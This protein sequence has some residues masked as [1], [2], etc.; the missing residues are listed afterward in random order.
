M[1]DVI[2]C[3]D[4]HLRLQSKYQH[5]LFE[6]GPLFKAWLQQV[7]GISQVQLEQGVDLIELRFYFAEQPWFGHYEHYTDS[8]WLD[9]ES[10]TDLQSMTDLAN[11]LQ[12]HIGQSI[13]RI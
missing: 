8:Y 5:D 1:F 13:E 4:N 10:T 3:H 7:P 11:A 9:T 6:I 12:I 2:E